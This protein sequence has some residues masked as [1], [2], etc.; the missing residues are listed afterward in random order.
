MSSQN[1]NVRKR[2]KPRPVGPAC[3][4]FCLI[5]LTVSSWAAA[6]PIYKC[7]D[8]NLGLLYTDEPC[9]DGEQLSVA[10][11]AADPAAVA[12]LERQREALDQSAM[13]R[14]HDQHRDAGRGEYASSLRYDP[15]AEGVSYDDG[16]ASGA[17][18]LVAPETF[19]HH[20]SM[21]RKPR[22]RQPGHFAPAPPYVVPRH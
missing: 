15:P 14:I 11:D 1:L 18:Y 6:A 8:K 17:E 16:V 7:F 2:K 13:Q 19:M 21:R 10:P 3:L 9:P 12:L 20:H 22:H 4:A 5:A